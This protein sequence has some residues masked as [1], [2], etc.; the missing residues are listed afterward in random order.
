MAVLNEVKTP[1]S[2]NISMAQMFHLIDNSRL[3]INVGPLPASL[4]HNEYR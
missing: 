4:F 1:T 3:M 2:I